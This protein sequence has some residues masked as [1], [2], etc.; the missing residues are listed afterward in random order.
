MVLDQKLIF[1]GASDN[2]CPLPLSSAHKLN[3][4]WTGK[5]REFRSKIDRLK[6][7]GIIFPKKILSLSRVSHTLVPGALNNLFSHFNF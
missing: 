3:C 5:T 1:G 7:E 2:H 4:P 6:I